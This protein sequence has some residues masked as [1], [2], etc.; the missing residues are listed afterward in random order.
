MVVAS[1][2]LSVKSNLTSGGSVHPEITVSYSAGNGGKKIWVFSETTSLQRSSTAP[3]KAIYL[4]GW[5][6]S[7]ESAHAQYNQYRR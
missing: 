5:P 3:L 2:C 1:V 4:Y 6:F 7:A